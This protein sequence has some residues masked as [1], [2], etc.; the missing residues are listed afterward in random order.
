MDQNTN[1]VNF[2]PSMESNCIH[3]KVWDEITYPFL[4]FNGAAVGM[5]CSLGMDKLFHP[6]LYRACDYLSKLGLKL[7]HVS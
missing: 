7:N 1:M 4:N 5:S 6:T 3:Y 2:N